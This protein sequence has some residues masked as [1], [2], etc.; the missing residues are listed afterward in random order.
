MAVRS[1]G[2]CGSIMVYVHVSAV[3]QFSMKMRQL[4]L[5]S[6]VYVPGLP[7]CSCFNGTGSTYVEDNVHI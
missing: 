3:V 2:S 6:V 4:V 1:Q 5:P 7:H